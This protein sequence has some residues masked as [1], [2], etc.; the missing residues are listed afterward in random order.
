MNT[1]RRALLAPE[2]VRR[3]VGIALSAALLDDPNG[4]PGPD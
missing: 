3:S 4:P 2:T 1:V